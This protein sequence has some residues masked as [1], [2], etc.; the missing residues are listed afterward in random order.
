[1][2]GDDKEEHKN[3]AVFSRVLQVIADEIFLWFKKSFR[4]KVGVC[5]A[6]ELI[7]LHGTRWVSWGLIPYV[8]TLN[9]MMSCKPERRQTLE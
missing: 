8:N 6:G 9:I 1:M 7:R 2:V 3:Q 5:L 4:C